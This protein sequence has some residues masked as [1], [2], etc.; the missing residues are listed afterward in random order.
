[1]IC[2]EPDVVLSGR[3]NQAQAA[4]VLGVDRHTVRRYEKLGL[5]SFRMKSAV[6]RKVTTGADIVRLW[7]RLN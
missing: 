3:Y 5:I 2:T 4:K 7:K 6:G 1:M